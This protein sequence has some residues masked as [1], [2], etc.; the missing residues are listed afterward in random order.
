MKNLLELVR[1]PEKPGIEILNVIV[2]NFEVFLK[3]FIIVSEMNFS[4]I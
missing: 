2:L 3:Y 1:K 4:V